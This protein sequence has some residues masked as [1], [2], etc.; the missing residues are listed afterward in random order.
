MLFKLT[1]GSV[2]RR[3]SRLFI[4]LAA[5]TVGA[6]TVAALSAIYL[7]LR[8]QMTRELRS[9]GANLIVVPAESGSSPAAI[10]GQ[11]LQVL[12]SLAPPGSLQGAVPYLHGLVDVSDGSRQARTP[13][14]GTIFAEALKVNPYWKIA[15]RVPAA[16][17]EVLVGT[18]VARRL[19]LS[20]GNSLTLSPSSSAVVDQDA[21]TA[22]GETPPPADRGTPLELQVSGVLSTG[23][24]EDERVF[25][26]LSQAQTLLG[27]PDQVSSVHLSIL[28]QEPQLEEMAA[29]IQ[30]RLPQLVTRPVTRVSQS[31]GRVLMRLSLLFY[32]VVGIV[33]VTSALGVIIT[34]LNMALERRKELGLK[35]ALGAENR[36]LL[37]ELL[38]EAGLIGLMGSLLG[39]AAGFFLARW[40]GWSVFD[41]SISPR[42]AIVPVTILV[43]LVMAGL[44]VLAPIRLAAR[45]DPAVTLKEE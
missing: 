22:G 16:P 4:A 40:I 26:D 13:V 14:T 41:S 25:L 44:A 7:D 18:L 31:E 3:R 5:V 23:G 11:Q 12:R 15:G 10:S 43:S 30:N 8:A 37:A 9:Y 19:A 24:A 34:M 6:A 21:S 20:P 2:R 45:I 35:K 36:H 17:G 32:L 39:I 33:L 38:G 27:R 29:R 28:G 1:L 42:P